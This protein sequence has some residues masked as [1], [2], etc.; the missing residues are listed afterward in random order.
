MITTPLDLDRIDALI[1]QKKMLLARAERQVA[2]LK[3]EIPEL[4][5]ARAIVATDR[6]QMAAN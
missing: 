6:S 2:K 1:R 5:R 4:E 3:I